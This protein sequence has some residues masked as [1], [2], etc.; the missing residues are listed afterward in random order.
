MLGQGTCPLVPLVPDVDKNSVKL[1]DVSVYKEQSQ[2]TKT[3]GETLK[4]EKL[5]MDNEDNDEATDQE[6]NR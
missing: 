2:D 1:N 5:T 6:N 3:V 4:K